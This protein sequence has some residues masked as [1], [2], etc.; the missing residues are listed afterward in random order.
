MAWATSFNRRV[1]N[2]VWY[3]SPNWA[4]FSGRVQYGATSG[5][6]S[7]ATNDG[8]TF[9]ASVKPQLWSV[10]LNYT[11]GGL[12]AGLGYEYHKDYITAATRSI[13]AAGFGDD[14]SG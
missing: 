14:C 4:G 3:Q 9:P 8:S 7:N 5:A 11:L 2:S 12:Y 13:G 1:D 10:G 6:T